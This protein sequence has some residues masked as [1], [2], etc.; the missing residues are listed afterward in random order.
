MET[1]TNLELSKSKRCRKGFLFRAN[2]RIHFV[3]KQKQVL[4][5]RLGGFMGGQNLQEQNIKQMETIL[6][7]ANNL[8]EM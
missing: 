6:G 8:K 2:T 7:K 4:K 1:L 3:D 5:G